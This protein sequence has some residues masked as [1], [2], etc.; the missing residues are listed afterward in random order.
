[1]VDHQTTSHAALARRR[2]RM[3]RLIAVLIL[4]LGIGGAGLLYWRSTRAD[5]WSSDPAMLGYDR[6]QTQET[7]I[8]YGKQ[9]E[10]FASLLHALKQP[11]TQASITLIAAILVSVSYFKIAR[12]CD[13]DADLN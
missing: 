13:V 8:L 10:L 9:G 1:M 6:A 12:L 3:F 4:V 2:A 5:E 7:D 11:R